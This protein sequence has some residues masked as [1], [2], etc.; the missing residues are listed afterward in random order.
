[1]GE[2]LLEPSQ[3]W[4]EWQEQV[5][6]HT[7]LRTAWP[8]SDGPL[9]LLCMCCPLA[10]ELEGWARGA[11]GPFLEG[12]GRKCPSKEGC[13]SEPRSRQQSSVFALPP[14]R[15]ETFRQGHPSS[16]T[17]PCQCPSWH[18]ARAGTGSDAVPALCPACSTHH[19]CTWQAGAATP[20]PCCSAGLSSPSQAGLCQVALARSG[21]L[22][23][24]C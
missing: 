13:C 7:E 20:L 18:R 14:W 12:E 22:L 17:L 2:L 4:L 1:M 23:W 21:S 9:L 11:I 3:C 24:P 15:E 8:C 6:L 19:P 10:P 16:P 5:T